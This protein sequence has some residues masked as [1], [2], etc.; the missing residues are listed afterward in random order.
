MALQLNIYEHLIDDFSSGRVDPLKHPNFQLE[1]ARVKHGG[2]ARYSAGD[3]RRLDC[4]KQHQQLVS[5]HKE[6]V[7]VKMHIWIPALV[8]GEIVQRTESKSVSTLELNASCHHA[9]VL[10]DFIATSD[11]PSARG[12]LDGLMPGRD[13]WE[14]RC[15]LRD[16]RRAWLPANVT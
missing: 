7:A 8:T 15:D 12:N 10:L 4:L 1:V 5:P 2:K 16:L 6:M 14:W 9:R 13:D 3:G 11:V